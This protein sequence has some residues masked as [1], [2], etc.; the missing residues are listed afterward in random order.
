MALKSGHGLKWEIP[1]DVGK[2][3]TDAL[4]SEIKV[5]K[6]DGSFEWKTIRERNDYWD[7]ECFIMILAIW[8]KI[9]PAL[10]YSSE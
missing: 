1:H 6:P 4:N 7:C 9:Y 8:H 2:D 10:T 5:A 3:Y